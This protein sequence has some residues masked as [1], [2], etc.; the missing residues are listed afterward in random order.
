[1]LGAPQ[2]GMGHE[3]G[4][5]GVVT[6]TAAAGN[7]LARRVFDGVQHREV[8]VP[9]GDPAFQLELR[10]AAGGGLG[11]DLQAGAAQMV[12]I[13]MGGGHADEIHAAVQAAVEGEVGALGVHPLQ[14]LV[15]A[16]ND[17][18]VVFAVLAEIRHISAEF[19]VAALMVGD[20]LAVDVHIRLLTGGV[21]LHVDPAAGQRL[22]GGGEA[23]GVPEGAAGIAAVAVHAVHGVPAVGQGHVLPVGGQGGGQTCVRLNEFP[24]LVE[25]DDI[26][27][28]R[29]PFLF[30][31]FSDFSIPHPAAGPLGKFLAIWV[32]S[33]HGTRNC[34]AARFVRRRRLSKPCRGRRP[35]H[36][37]PFIPASTG[38][39]LRQV[40]R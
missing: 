37:V 22:F 12:Q 17:Q 8:L 36:P 39:R 10:A 25:G 16:G 21:H 19:G 35:R 3:Q 26:A 14:T 38:R 24:A 11:R 20:L 28:K 2:L 6:G 32:N 1:M 15:G 27:H 4:D 31:N 30:G 33:L 23:A 18:Q 9:A 7:L 29:S 13:K 34:A 40:W 5:F